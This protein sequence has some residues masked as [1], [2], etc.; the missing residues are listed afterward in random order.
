MKV[1]VLHHIHQMT[2]EQ[3]DVKL[4]GIYS[5][6]E[7]AQSAQDRTSRL[8]GFRDAHGGFQ[9]DEY[10]VDVDCWTEGYTTF[11][12]Y[13][14]PPDIHDATV[15]RLTQKDDVATVYL[16]SSEGRPFTL[17]FSGITNIHAIRPEGML[18]YALAE[19]RAESPLRRFV[20]ANWDE[21]DKATLE[22]IAKDWCVVE[23]VS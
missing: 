14:G 4:I 11:V 19:M 6:Y 18:L 12:A 8:D 22:I 20:F 3:D 10:D 17:E 15:L 21:E 23:T 1:F 9:I 16:R 5:T 2:P 7:R 13:V